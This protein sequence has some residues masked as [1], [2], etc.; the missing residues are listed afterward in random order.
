MKFDY[1]GSQ[2]R[3]SAICAL[4]LSF[5]FSAQSVLAASALDISQSPLYT[6]TSAQV[7]PNLMFILD[8]SGSM[9][10]DFLPDDAPSYYSSSVDDDTRDY[11]Y[12]G[13]T[14]SQCNGVAYNPNLTYTLPVDASG[15]EY[16]KPSFTA[17]CDNGFSKVCTV[18][19][20]TK[21]NYNYYYKYTGKEKPL[22][23]T[24]KSGSVDTSSNFYKECYSWIGDSP[25]K[26]VFTRVDVTSTSDESTNYAIWYSFY[27]KRMLVMKT[28]ATQAFKN[29]NNSFRVG[30]STISYTGADSANA[31]FLAIDDFN[32][33]AGG[34]REKFYTK[35][36]GASGSSGTPLLGALSKA[37]RIYG[38][39]LGSDPVQYSCQQNFTLLSTD[40][41]WN[42]ESTGYGAYALDNST[43]VGQQDGALEKPMWDGTISI[44][45]VTTPLTRIDT[46]T[47]PQTVTDVFKRTVTTTT[48]RIRTR[49]LTVTKTIYGTTT[50]G[51]TGGKVKQT[52]STATGTQIETES[53]TGTT[54]TQTQEQTVITEQNSVKTLTM[55]ANRTVVTTD[56]KTAPPTTS[57]WT[58]SATSAAT[59]TITSGPTSGEWVDVGTPTTGTTGT[60]T[61][62]KVPA[63][64][65]AVTFGTASTPVASG[66]CKS[67]ITLPSPNPAYAVTNTG[68]WSA[69]TATTPVVVG[70]PTTAVR[71]AGYPATVSGA[72]T[73]TEGSSI[74]EGSP[75][76]ST[77]GSVT[78]PSDTLA[79]VAAYYYNTDLRYPDKCTSGSA[80][81]ANLCPKDSSGN[82]VPNVPGTG[83][84]NN[85]HPHMTT[86]TLGLGVDG[87]LDY[88]STYLTD[89]AGDYVAL[90]K[91]DK[92]WPD[93]RKKSNAERIDDLWHAAVNGHGQ[94]FSAKEPAALVKSLSAALA[95]MSTRLGYGTA[96][97]TSN[98][99]PIEGDNAL[100]VASFT[101]AQWTGNLVAESI[102]PKTGAIVET[103]AWCLE[104]IPA[105]SV[106]GT[107][108]CTG[109]LA[110]KVGADSDTRTIYFNK[111]G[112]LSSFV[113]DNLSNDQ[114]GW[115]APSKLS[116]WSSTYSDTAKTAATTESL[117]NYLRGQRQHEMNEGNATQLYRARKGTFGDVINSQPVYIG[118]P[119]S[120]FNDPGY[121]DWRNGT[122]R[123]SR[124]KTVFVGANDGMLHAVDSTNGNERWAF[125]PTP[126]M[127]NLYW[128]ADATYTTNHRYYVDGNL[129]YSDICTANC[130]D[131]EKAEWKTILVGGLGGGG[132]G[133]FAFDVTDSSSPKFLWEFTSLDDA[134]LGYTY[135]NPVIAKN[136]SGAWKVMFTSGYN[137]IKQ[138]NGSPF[139]ADGSGQGALFVVDPLKGPA[140]YKKISTGSGTKLEP[141]GLSRIAAWADDP[142]TDA[143][144]KYIYGGDLNGNVWRFDINTDEVIK[145]AQLVDA[146][147]D[148]QPIT[149]R[150][151][152]TLVSGAR[153]LY[154]GTGKYLEG[155]DL[156]SAN[157]KTQ[158]VYAFIDTEVNA[159]AP[160]FDTA[161]GKSILRSALVKQTLTNTKPSRKVT[162]NSVSVPSQKGW[163]V[164][165]P[166]TGERVSVD[167]RLAD[168]TLLVASNVPTNGVCEAGGYSWL[169]F[170][171]YRTGSVVSGAT[172]AG[173]WTGNDLTTGLNVA[174]IG[175]KPQVIRTGS[176][177]APS[178]IS[179]VPFGSSGSGVSGHRVSWRE[180]YAP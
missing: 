129:A 135:G 27:R 168:G 116:Q 154:F 153:M 158:T 160:Y 162:S 120:F 179:G 169:N 1:S 150:P 82:Y 100:Y 177:T 156:D 165:L 17:A 78:G 93:P 151:D 15:A 62:A 50:S 98:L 134:D 34:Q 39:M 52:S 74:T 68:A 47:T 139:D 18:N 101:T 111:A 103:A 54:S 49:T 138:K 143:T 123:Q 96:A 41:Y 126:V 141:S 128:L 121:I 152:M 94:Y 55:K 81:K 178:V 137:N 144:A 92:V 147:G 175:S 83:L 75:T 33:G 8:N 16:P 31:G 67:S 172:A 113:K 61:T 2:Y 117:V 3:R 87:T 10:W 6:A 164:D 26:D 28:A 12:Y 115:I 69:Y 91:G 105:D 97:A 84:D 163:Y 166:D 112:S 133:Y 35:L 63:S 20:S 86:F 30:F 88:S 114:I 9:Q 159:G 170:F 142:K 4:V 104:G 14:S 37:G 157:F 102:D 56:G 64:T 38:G 71:K 173:T 65:A 110:N 36:T 66:S 32:A 80:T 21:A 131:A 132:R 19:L 180:L 24:Y 125:V 146:S 25:G 48:P 76:T 122:D 70:S 167:P 22:S 57:T 124:P 90:K 149:T 89:T 60:A 171:N 42:S 23:Y 174:W 106:K 136:D 29:I 73:I 59:V 155:S 45:T 148:P 107:A 140:S 53:G 5:C 130:T 95:G 85:P 161:T 40:G 118:K 7:K 58:L 119:G 13:G 72:V 145:L 11:D 77:T 44:S 127:H 51:C 79:D 99:A 43:K 108:G 46:E 176:G 109:A